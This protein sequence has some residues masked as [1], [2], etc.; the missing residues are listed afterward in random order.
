MSVDEM[1]VVEMTADMMSVDK[2][3]YYSFFS[4]IKSIY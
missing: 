1:F 2:M 4:V 3:T